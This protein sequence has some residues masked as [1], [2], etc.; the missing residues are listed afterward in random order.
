MVPPDELRSFHA[1]MQSTLEPA[2]SSIKDFPD[3]QEVGSEALGWA[4][5]VEAAQEDA[6][7][8]VPGEL[9]GRIAESSCVPLRSQ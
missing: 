1:S 6:V 2:L 8:T 5:A 9:R 7:E 4:L 3:N